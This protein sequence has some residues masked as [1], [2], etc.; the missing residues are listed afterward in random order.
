M[1]E[2]ARNEAKKRLGEM[3]QRINL[4]QA[5]RDAK[6]KG[7]TLVQAY[8]A[9]I[10][11]RDLS[12]VSLRVY[13]KAMQP[14]FADWKNKSI[15]SINRDLIEA[16]FNK[17]SEKNQAQTNQMFLFLRALLNFAKEKYTLGDDEPLVQSN[18]CDRLTVL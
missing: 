6:I 8:E 1:P 9:H 15:Q 16:R 11:T 12:K 13:A 10:Q 17:L 2:Q 18:P 7:I 4:N 5:D 14:G 3:T